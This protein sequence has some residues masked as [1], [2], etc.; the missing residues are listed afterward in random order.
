MATTIERIKQ[1]A[2]TTNG[3]VGAALKELAERGMCRTGWYQ[4]RGNYVKSVD[5]T[6]EVS[7]ALDSI[8]VRYIKFND[9]VRGGVGGCKVC[10]ASQ[11]VIKSLGD[12]YA[13]DTTRRA[14][15]TYRRL[16]RKSKAVEA[17]RLNKRKA[18][19]LAAG[20]TRSETKNLRLVYCEPKNTLDVI[21]NEYDGWRYSPSTFSQEIIDEI[22]K[23]AASW[24]FAVSEEALR[25]NFASWKADLK[26]N[27]V[28]EEVSVFTPCGCNQ[29]AFTIEENSGKAHQ[30]TY[31]C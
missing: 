16:A 23:E 24:G 14:I 2:D 7:Q 13:I 15:A 29:L 19:D 4:G 22:I 26:S 6:R 31:S 3:A 18:E 8:H 20:I 28:S 10:L 17:E 1:K 25:H 5:I 9:A 27:H 21:V 30:F 12:K 11:K